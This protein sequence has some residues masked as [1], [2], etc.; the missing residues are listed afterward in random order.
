MPDSRSVPRHTGLGNTGV[1]SPW[2]DVALSTCH[3]IL[4]QAHLFL[5]LLPCLGSLVPGVWVGQTQEGKKAR[6][7]LMWQICQCYWGSARDTLQPSAAQGVL[8]SHCTNCCVCIC[9]SQ[10]VWGG[11]RTICIFGSLPLPCGSWI[12]NSGRQIWL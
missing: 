11:Q 1:F 12:W 4:G 6:K 5:R 9:V 3:S 2:P 10:P 8:K 7:R